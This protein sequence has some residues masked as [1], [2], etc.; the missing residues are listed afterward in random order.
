MFL[1]SQGF[2]ALTVNYNRS[3]RNY[4]DTLN[5]VRFLKRSKYVKSS[6]VSIVGFSR[7]AKQAVYV[8]TVEPL[9]CIVP[10]G[11]R[12]MTE[13]SSVDAPIEFAAK[14][15]C[16]ILLIH[17]KG[18]PVV[19]YENSVEMEKALSKAGKRVKLKTYEQSSHW[20]GGVQCLIDAVNFIGK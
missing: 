12:H 17:S 15:N 5:A 16:P 7:G 1:A 2:V 9:R 3:N 4:L 20:P 11:G 10:I 18:D 19:P 8:S 13:E 6:S 14:V